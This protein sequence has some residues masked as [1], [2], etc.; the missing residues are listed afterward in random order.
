V[1]CPSSNPNFVDELYETKKSN[2]RSMDGTIT[3]E[4]RKGRPKKG[5][6]MHNP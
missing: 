5:Q 1:A 2:K 4:T 3:R 6:K